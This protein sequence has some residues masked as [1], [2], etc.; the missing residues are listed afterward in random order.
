MNTPSNFI[1][2]GIAFLLTLA[3]GLWLSLAGKPYNG[4]LFNTHK[5]I[6]LGAVVVT[7]MQIYQV[8]RALNLRPS[9]PC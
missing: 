1:T 7:S 9:S 2:P 4:L 5:L 3:F 6:A 8:S